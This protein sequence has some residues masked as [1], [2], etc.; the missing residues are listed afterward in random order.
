MSIIEKVKGQVIEAVIVVV[1]AKVVSVTILE[2]MVKR[3]ILG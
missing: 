3:I 1:T 2:V